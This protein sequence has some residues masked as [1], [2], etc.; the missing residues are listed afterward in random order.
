MKHMKIPE[1][2]K[3]AI[4]DRCGYCSFKFKC[5]K[6]SVHSADGNKECLCVIFLCLNND[7]NRCSPMEMEKKACGEDDC[8]G[9]SDVCVLPKVLGSCNITQTLR[10]VIGPSIK[11]TMKKLPHSIRDGLMRAIAHMPHGKCIE[12]VVCDL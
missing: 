6:R 11:S 5:R 10:K 2:I 3:D 7:S 4:P 12:C 8:E 1:A 9:C